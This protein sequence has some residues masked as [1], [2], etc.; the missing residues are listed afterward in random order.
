LIFEVAPST[1][2]LILTNFV[3]QRSGNPSVMRLTIMNYQYVYP[4]LDILQPSG[5]I[6]AANVSEFQALIAGAVNNPENTVT[7][8]D[9]SR[10]EFLDSA[11]LMV[12]VSAFRMAQSLSKRFSLCSLAPSV[13]IIFELT[14]L[15]RAFEIFEDRKDFEANLRHLV[16][17]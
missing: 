7:L 10:V 8:I 11:G 12:L 17:A 13:R 5:Y 1:I 6:T 9:M 15:D 4:A 16:A 14:Q 3:I 2:A